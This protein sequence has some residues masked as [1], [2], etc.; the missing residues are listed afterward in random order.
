MD[1]KEI[2]QAINEYQ[3][4][5]GH[6]TTKMTAQE[7]LEY[8]NNM[9]LGLFME[10]AEL[11]DSTPWKPWRPVKDQTFDI[12]NARVEIIDCIFF[13]VGIAR[14]MYITAEDLEAEFTKKLEENYAR[15][16]SGYNHTNG[17]SRPE[18]PGKGFDDFEY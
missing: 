13:L 18:E 5:L 16:T 11:I 7:L 9:S 15:I 6:D 10:V 8:R 4:T 12:P 2:Y 17:L 3:C 14:S 1:F